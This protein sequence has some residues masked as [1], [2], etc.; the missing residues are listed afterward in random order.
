MKKHIYILWL[1]IITV[2]AVG[3]SEDEDL[4]EVSITPPSN[5]EAKVTLSQDNSGNVEILP[6]A[7]NANTFFIDYGDGSPV[8]DTLSSG[9]TFSHIYS[10][11][12]FDLTIVALNVSGQTTELVKPLEISFLPPENLEVTVEKDANNPFLVRVSASADNSVGLD[13]TFGE[14]EGEEPVSILSGEEATY[15]YSSVGTFLITVEALSGGEATTTFTEEVTITDPFVIPITFESET[16]N[17][18]FNNFGGGEGVGVPIIDNPVPN[19][20]NDSQ[21][22]GSYTK[23]SGSQSFAGTSAQLNENIDFSTTTTLSMDIWSP[24]AGVPVLFKIEQEGNPDIFVESIQN[25]TV[26]N[27]WE[28]LNF[29]LTGAN[30][31]DFSI[32]AIFFNFNIS[33]SGETY[34]FDNIRLTNPVVLGLPLNFEQ[35][36][37]VYNF[38]EFGGAPTE[39]IE[40]P[41]PTGINLSAN[42]AKTLKANGAENFAGSFID[43]NEPIDLSV[44][45]T[46][47]LKVW[48]PIPNSDIILKLENPVTGA[49]TEIT[50]TITTA[51]EWVELEFD[52]SGA[53]MNE[54]WPRIVFF[55][56]SGNPGS[57]LEFFFDDLDYITSSSESLVGTW[58][59]AGEA[60]SL[61]VGPVI[62][63]TSF[64]ACDADCVSERAC[65]FN[66]TYTFNADG[67]FIN[68]FGDDNLTWVEQWQS[69]SAD[70][71]GDTVVPH[72]GSNSATYAFDALDNTITLSGIGAYIGLPKAVNAGELPIVDVP[73]EVTYTV[74]FESPTSIN[75]YIESGSGVFWQYKLVKQ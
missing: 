59:M 49:E 68:G 14:F 46:L 7:Q 27:Q 69:D 29:N 9:E 34:F 70:A 28:T 56:D 73:D 22:V 53:D 3:C 24:E 23:V 1:S 52:F 12:N 25:T 8:S 67:T 66:D 65:Y 19:D 43:V 55:F 17:Y 26:A 18:Q 30:G 5:V 16:V 37:S 13:I 74:S 4:Q 36:A 44:S 21:K 33:G 72:D 75:V 47:S 10:E 50:Q 6:T 41:D 35:E 71:C 11:G 32:I 42:V 31:N 40:N 54:E 64:F 57:G 51:N 38:T 20:V 62:G 45:S 2:F 48:S 39:V 63:D 15:T 60:G 58:K 61:G